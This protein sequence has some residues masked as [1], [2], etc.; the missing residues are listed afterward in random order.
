MSLKTLTTALF[1][2]S[3]MIGPATAQDVASLND[4]EFAHVAYTADNIDIRYAHLALAISTNPD[5]HTFANTMI[6]DHTAVN[7]AALGLLGK[8]GATAQDNFFSQALNEG[9]EKII[10][11]FSK[12]RGAEFD[13]AYAA[14]ELAYHQ[15]VNDLVENTMIPN[16]DNAEVKALFQQGLDIFKVHEGHAEMMVKAVN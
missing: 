16:I 7:A 9:A 4:L 15:T 3:L 11:D 5:I 6:S 12:L 8:L 14:N 10:D 13:A 1:A 2:G